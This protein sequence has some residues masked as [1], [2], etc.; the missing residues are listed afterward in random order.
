MFQHSAMSEDAVYSLTEGTV[1]ISISHELAN[2]GDA[3]TITNGAAVLS[4]Q[5][6]Q[7]PDRPRRGQTFTADSETWEVEQVLVSDGYVHKLLVVPQ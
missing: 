2:W 5:V 4:V 6:S 7:V 3:V 1:R